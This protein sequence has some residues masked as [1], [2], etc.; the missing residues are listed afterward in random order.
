MRSSSLKRFVSFTL[1]CSK[2]TPLIATNSSYV[3]IHN[4]INSNT[5]NFSSQPDWMVVTDP[6]VHSNQIK[7]PYLREST[8]LEI[9]NRFKGIENGVQGEEWSISRLSQH[10]SASPDR[11]KVIIFINF[12]F[13]FIN[14]IFIILIQAVIY[15]FENKEK[16]MREN[17]LNEISQDWKDIFYKSQTI[18]EPKQG[19]TVEVKKLEKGDFFIGTSAHDL[20]E[21]YKLSVD[22]IK[23]IVKK[24]KTHTFNMEN[25]KYYES[26]MEG[27]LTR[28]EER[29]VDTKFRETAVSLKRSS[30]KDN[31][32]PEL[33][34]DTGE[35]EA[36]R[37]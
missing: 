31:Y 21:E 15:L 26:E 6:A 22:E 33:F 19:E 5:R 8:K 32:F 10:Y 23:E 25:M 29:G 20:A 34:G 35:E 3:N 7:V 27:I 13:Y 16:I 14:I 37:K 24:M 1:S 28:L 17:K 11:I 9:Y 18:I 12:Y 4:L 30:V 36:K 2:T